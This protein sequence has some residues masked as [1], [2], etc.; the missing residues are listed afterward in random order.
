MG[1]SSILSTRK[2]RVLFI[3][4]KEPINPDVPAFRPT[5]PAFATEQFRL[6]ESSD[7]NTRSVG[8]NCDRAC[9]RVAGGS[10]LAITSLP[11]GL[12]SQNVASHGDAGSPV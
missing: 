8:P 10:N 5:Q 4:R 11:A 9:L 3:V 2:Q 1:N 12:R 7:K 6:D